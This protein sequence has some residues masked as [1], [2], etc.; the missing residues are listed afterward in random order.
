[1]KFSRRKSCRP[2]LLGEELVRALSTLVWFE[3]KPLFM[4]VHAMLR[5]LNAA[6]AGE[7]MLRLRLYDKLQN[8]VFVGAAEKSGKSYRGNAVGLDT[9]KKLK[10]EQR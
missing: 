1:M 3:F 2:D 10:G 7:E 6:G 9:F 8:L 5:A 4:E